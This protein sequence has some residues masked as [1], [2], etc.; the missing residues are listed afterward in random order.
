LNAQASIY[1]Q[2]VQFQGPTYKSA[3][4]ISVSEAREMG[5][6]NKHET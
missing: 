6:K 5:K 2:S 3:Q 1:G 4:F